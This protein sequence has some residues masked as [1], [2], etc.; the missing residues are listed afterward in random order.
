[1]NLSP[2]ENPMH[3]LTVLCFAL[4]L[5]VL[6][7]A[8]AQKIEVTG[9]QHSEIQYRLEQDIEP[10]P[11]LR[12]LYVSFVVPASFQSQTYSQQIS[13]LNFELLPPPGDQKSETDARGN[14]I[15]TY[16]WTN[17]PG[18][19]KAAV[20][21]R[22]ANRV[23]LGTLQDDG[24]PFPMRNLSP[25]VNIF[26]QPTAQVQSDHPAIQDKAKELTA[27]AQTAYQACQNI[28]YWV[29]EHMQ[30]VL[31][32]EQYDAMY[33]FAYG[34]GN[35]QNYSH[36]AAALMRASGIPARIVNG[37][38]LDRPYTLQADD[39]QYQ[40][41]M[42]R[43]RHSWIEVYFP[44]SGW[45]PFDPQQSEFFVSNRYVRI[46]IG[47]DN[48]ESVNDGLVRWRQTSGSARQNPKLEEVIETNFVRDDVS[49]SGKRM[50][51][52]DKIVLGPPLASVAAPPLAAAEEEKKQ[53]PE[54]EPRPEPEPKAE[55]P[56]PKTTEPAAAE[57]DYSKLIYS[58]PFVYG[59]LDFPEGVD[60]A[61]PRQ[62]SSG[63]TQDSYQLQRSFL[64]ETAEYVTSQTQFAQCVVLKE[65]I[66]LEKIGLA[67]HNF[68]G[69][70]YLWLELSEDENGK[71][72]PTAVSTRKIP[73]QY[74][75]TRQGYQWV[76][77]PFEGIVLSPGRYW[78][79]LNFSGGPIVNWFYSYG[80]PVGPAD[81]TRARALGASDWPTI[82]SFE[83]N[84]RVSGKAV[85]K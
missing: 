14:Q 40:F 54:P 79:F 62:A 43:G 35:C 38:T 1:M 10:F 27:P 30:Y 41:E 60:F 49:L 25:D 11:G 48:E 84:Y 82:L 26:L 22:A 47:V 59:N 6:T 69:S 46:E 61:F 71:P 73:L 68:G 8:V 58:E 9:S 39:G 20:T 2:K 32:P 12:E 56:E 28:L 29:V 7:I 16:T 31:I 36:L 21:F 5:S 23:Q 83:F 45:L 55:E 81:G 13:D 34:K 51:G 75:V 44:G 64:V 19:I 74:I 37:I 78:F 66:R 76:D 57:I 52:V 65:P 63:Q 77:F 72:G 42:A 24:T 3:R 33:S 15:R 70:G 4:I 53:E 67:M 50:A 80:K 17:P 85:K 18:A